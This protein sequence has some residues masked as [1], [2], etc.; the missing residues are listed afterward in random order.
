[1]RGPREIQKIPCVLF[2]YFLEKNREAN[3][4]KKKKNHDYFR[5]N[6]KVEIKNSN[7]SYLTF[8]VMLGSDLARKRMPKISVF[9]L[10]AATNVGVS[11]SSAKH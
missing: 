1:M 7:K 10:S 5:G 4:A 3:V 9:P 6:A 11:P 8:Q 2:I